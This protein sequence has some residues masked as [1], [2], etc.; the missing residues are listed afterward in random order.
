M[1]NSIFGTGRYGEEQD[2]DAFR[3]GPTGAYSES[4]ATVSGHESTEKFK[5]F[6]VNEFV[7]SSNKVGDKFSEFMKLRDSELAKL[8]EEIGLIDPMRQLKRKGHCIQPGDIVH[9]DV[10]R[11]FKQLF[12]KKNLLEPIGIKKVGERAPELTKLFEIAYDVCKDHLIEIAKKEL[13]KLFEPPAH[14]FT[15]QERKNEEIYLPWQSR[16]EALSLLLSNLKIQ[17]MPDDLTV[18]VTKKDKMY[19]SADMQTVVEQVIELTWRMV[20]LSPPVSFGKMSFSE[21]L[22]VYD[23]TDMENLLGE[24]KKYIVKYRRPVLFFGPLGIVGYKG[25]VAIYP[26]QPEHSTL[27]EQGMLIDDASFDNDAPGVSD[28]T[29]GEECKSEEDVKRTDLCASSKMSQ[30]SASCPNGANQMNTSLRQKKKKKKKK[31]SKEHKE[32]EQDLEKSDCADSNN[33]DDNELDKVD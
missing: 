13:E 4:F 14:V 22:D 8:E 31:K 23:V 11:D 19:E 25:S 9:D 2:T 6:V 12:D 29:K 5:K 17:F 1:G 21:D 24:G 10:A 27:L 16:Q 3:M 18:E 30:E 28:L 32:I 33:S 7:K 26:P 15:E 20:N